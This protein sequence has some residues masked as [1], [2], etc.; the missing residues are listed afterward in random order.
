M[1]PSAS[2]LLSVQL[3]PV[4]QNTLGHEQ[5]PDVPEPDLHKDELDSIVGDVSEFISLARHKM[6][7]VLFNRLV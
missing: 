1:M 6:A 7:A 4:F 3:A 2:L 5:D